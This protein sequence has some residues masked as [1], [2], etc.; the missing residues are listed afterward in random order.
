VTQ[1]KNGQNKILSRP[2]VVA[3]NHGSASIEQKSEGNPDIKLT[4]TPTFQ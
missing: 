2:R 3:L 1:T 4:V